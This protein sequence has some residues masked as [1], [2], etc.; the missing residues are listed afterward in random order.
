MNDQLTVF[1][2][3]LVYLIGMLVIGFVAA[4]RADSSEEFLV[5]GRSL[6]LGLCTATLTATW[7]GSGLVIGAAGAAYEGGFL[8]VIADPFGAALCLFLAGF[9]F[10]RIL[11]ARSLAPRHQFSDIC[12]AYFAKFVDHHVLG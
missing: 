12:E 5:A 11:I 3:I 10:V 9:F 7:M 4:R 1:A 2:G 6:P 8:G